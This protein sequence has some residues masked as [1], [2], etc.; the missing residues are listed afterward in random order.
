MDGRR[1]Q[2]YSLVWREGQW[3]IGHVE[4]CYQEV[5]DVGILYSSKC[6]AKVSLTVL[7]VG[8]SQRTRSRDLVK[9]IKKPLVTRSSDFLRL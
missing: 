5:V 2:W 9:P 3:R 8:S 6:T 7:A 1:C 4:V